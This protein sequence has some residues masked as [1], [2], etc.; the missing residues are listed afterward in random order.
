MRKVLVVVLAALAPLAAWGAGSRDHGN[1]AD[2]QPPDQALQPHADAALDALRRME[3][4]LG[5]E[6]QASLDQT[7]RNAAA[8]LSAV[9]GIERGSRIAVLSMR[10]DSVRL[11][12]YLVDEMIVALMGVGG[13]GFAVV[14]RSDVELALVREQLDFDMSG[15]VDDQTAQ[16]IGRFMGVQF[17]VAGEFEPIAGFFR[18]RARIVEVE[19][20]AIRGVYAANVRSDDIIAYL[21]GGSLPAAVAAPVPVPPPPPAPAPPPPAPPP[22]PPPPVPAPAPPPP[23]QPA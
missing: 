3:Q 1:A 16:R 10:A 9:P 11:S 7:L 14:S 23:A 20:S 15:E 21:R 13:Q 19:T 4:A 2:A 8:Q 18:F 17:I 22:V 6:G 12:N 5:H